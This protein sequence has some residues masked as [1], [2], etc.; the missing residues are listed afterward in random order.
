MTIC[1]AKSPSHR[2]IAKTDLYDPIVLERAPL[3]ESVILEVRVEVKKPVVK[4]L[5][6]TRVARLDSQ[7]LRSTRTTECTPVIGVFLYQVTLHLFRK[8]LDVA[9]S[10]KTPK[11][12]SVVGAR[13][14]FIKVAP[15]HH[16][17]VRKGIAHELIHS[18]QHYD[19]SMSAGFFTDLNLPEPAV[20]LGVG[21][22]SHAEQTASIISGL[23]GALTRLSPDIVVIYGD[24][25]TTLAAAVVVSKRSEYLV[26][27]EAGL[28]SFNRQMPEEIN[29]IVA[30][31]LSHL[32]LAPTN[33]AMKLLESEGLA[34]R[35][36]LVGDVMVDALRNTEKKVCANPPTMPA[37]WEDSTDYVFATLHRAENTDDPTR[38]RQLI[39]R[40]GSLHRDVRLAAHPR[41]TARM[42]EFKISAAG[43]LSL[44]QPMSYPQTVHAVLRSVAVIT[45]SGGLQKE[46]ALLGRPC[47]TA[48]SE[49]EWTE[50]V[51]AG[52]NIVDSSLSAPLSEWVHHRR[53]PLSAS[54][55]GDGQTAHRIVNSLLDGWQRGTNASC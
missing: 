43:G 55:F 9:K 4:Y 34:S 13:P 14:Q 24:T 45:D 16:E 46:A 23:N 39:E 48:R 30:D 6:S 40:L 11:V 8:L 51:E 18:G 26:H 20:N 47:V 36:Q 42:S 54:V 7:V 27:V 35:S 37:G 1:G 2:T 12:V 5:D 38:L 21:S 15:V 44:W 3:D 22:G 32:L 25:N 49:T 31:H 19:D 17:L 29:R 52:W 41:L 53:S 50:T 28:R 33:A 10:I